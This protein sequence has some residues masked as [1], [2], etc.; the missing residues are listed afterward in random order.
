MFDDESFVD[1]SHICAK[2]LCLFEVVS[3]QYDGHTFFIE[4]TQK[5]PH[6]TSEFYIHSGGWFVEDEEFRVMDES[7]RYHETSFHPSRK[8][9]RLHVS[10]LPES[11]CFQ[12]LF[13][14]RCCFLSG[15]TV[16]SGLIDDHIVYGFKY[17]E[18]ELLGHYTYVFSGF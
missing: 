17:P 10:L 5:I 12:V 11:E 15:D 18:V 8:G 3:G 7:T 1:D 16:V 2:H 13:Y 4:I 9:F 6:P 14:I